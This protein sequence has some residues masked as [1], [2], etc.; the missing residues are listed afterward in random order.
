M[1]HSAEECFG[2]FSVHNSIRDGLVLP[3]GSRDNA[4]KQ[5]KKSKNKWK[6]ELKSFNKKNKIIFSISK[7]TVS[8]REINKINNIKAVSSK[9]H[10]DDSSNSSSDDLDCDSSL[11]SYSDS[12]EYRRPSG[13][14][15]IN[16][17]NRV[18]TNNVNKNKDQHND[19][20]YNNPTF[21]INIFNSSISTKDP[22]LLVTVSL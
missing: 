12:D 20:I 8:C 22:L 3:I 18:V 16:R 19:A 7:K 11:S 15:E 2:N 10:R 9:N 17:L 5:Y 6:K 1:L 4:V 14:K 21:D 13:R